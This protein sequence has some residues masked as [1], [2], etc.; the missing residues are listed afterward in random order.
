VIAVWEACP[1]TLVVRPPQV[2]VSHA[3]PGAPGSFKGSLV[4]RD[5]NRQTSVL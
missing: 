1:Y 4:F 5:L 2:G 3:F